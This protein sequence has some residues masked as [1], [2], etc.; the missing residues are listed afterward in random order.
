VATAGERSP[1]VWHFRAVTGRQ[2]TGRPTQTAVTAW[3][4]EGDALRKAARV[5]FK[6]QQGAAGRMVSDALDEKL[7]NNEGLC[8]T[9]QSPMT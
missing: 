4:G 2:A 6:P 3:D 5:A 9:S 7:E 1:G 8:D